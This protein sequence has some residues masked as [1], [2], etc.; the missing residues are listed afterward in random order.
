[1]S[2]PLRASLRLAILLGLAAAAGP[3]AATPATAQD[4]APAESKAVGQFF[5]I[6]E[7]ITD[8]VLD[9]LRLSAKPYVDRNAEKGV[10]P[11]L[12]FEF[13]PGESQPGQSSA[14]NAADLAEFLS[15][16]LGGASQ[17]IAYVPK[18]LRGYAVLGVLACDEIVM[19][20]DATLGPIAPPGRAISDA[21]RGVVETLARRKGRDED[22]LLGML[23]PT[24]DLRE[25]RTADRQVHFLPASDLEEFRKTHQVISEEFAWEGGARGVLTAERARDLNFTKLLARNR[26]RIAERYG[27]DSAADDPTLGGPV[28]PV[29]IRIK[30]P[31]DT[32]KDSYL[33]RRIGQALSGEGVNLIVFHFQSEGG[34]IEPASNAAR[35]ISGLRRQGVKTVAYVDQAMGLSAL[36]ALACDEIV[37]DLD[38]RMGDVVRSVSGQGEVE[39]IGEKW[40]S[41]LSDHAA[42]LAREKFHPEAVARAM[43][44]PAIVLVEARDNQAAGLVYTSL[45]EAEAEPGR[46]QVQRRVK[47]AGEVLTLDARLAVDV[48]L[49]RR[50]AESLESYL[51]A[52]GLG[53]IRVDEPTWVDA[54]VATLNTP[55]MSWLL[56]FIGIF[57][58]I[59]ELK[60]PGV[61]LP[62][63]CSALAF[64]LFFWGHYLGGTAD[65]LEIM[66]FLVGLICLALELFVFPGFGVFGVS[67]ILMILISVVMASHTFIWPTQDYEYR[68]MGR[69]LTQMTL[70]ILAVIAGAI[71]LGRYFPSLPLFRRMILVPE[72]AA[73]EFDAEFSGRAKPTPS[74]PDNALFF[75]LGETGRTTTVCRPSGKARFGE[76]LVDVTAD[77]FYVEADSPVEVVEV[78]GS[79][80]FVKKLG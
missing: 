27:L 37:V 71:V 74:D 29:L 65:R 70:T 78:R 64:L 22:L 61:G 15:T 7:P 51:A 58:L 16:G 41:V 23:D 39:A 21:A 50:S 11:I 67:G 8:A 30:G 40:I 80:V 79:R 17:I 33:R 2:S 49:A 32:I 24:L 20:E 10:A 9:E 45:A 75:L 56:L 14:G 35:A 68:Q 34:E 62:A 59:L 60:L 72:P 77:G 19:G 69:T 43:V 46:Y 42:D 44:D 1:M 4:A 3:G 18:P 48:E 63:I 73:G 76:M 5:T 66:L 31:V 13:L 53:R 54:L 26:A 47:P 28:R 38:G 36:L 25:V 52:T 57:M 55:W 6:T 12:I